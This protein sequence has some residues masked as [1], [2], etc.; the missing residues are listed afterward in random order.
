MGKYHTWYNGVTDLSESIKINPN[1]LGLLRGFGL[2]DYFRTYNK[3]PF[4]WDW[5]WSRFVNSAGILGIPVELSKSEALEIISSLINKNKDKEIAIRIL[6]TGGD[7][8]DS[9]T[10]IKPNLMIRSEHIVESPNET[11]EKGI[12][13]ITHCY[14]R[15]MPELKSTDYKRLLSLSSEIKRN[16]ATDVL[17]YDE[18]RISELSRS[19]IFL[20]KNKE[21]I[22]PKDG[23]LKGITRKTTLEQLAFNEF[24][25]TERDIQLSE[26]FEADEVFTTSSNKKILAISQIDG[27]K[28]GE[29]KAGEISKYLL[30][31]FNELTKNW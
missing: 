29:G 1:D 18:N 28:I 15:D 17:F 3:R 10:M 22:T 30:Q 21:L 16:K 12:S 24:K 6:L 11:Y 4:Q 13:I 27:K 19:N 5:Y 9:S 31:K 8:P 23:I 2:F 20:I 25:I 26:V 14:N 7:A